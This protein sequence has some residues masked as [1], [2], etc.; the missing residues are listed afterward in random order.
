MMKDFREIDEKLKDNA[1]GVDWLMIL[2]YGIDMAMVAFIAIDNTYA[3]F[4]LIA[5]VAYL[6]VLSILLCVRLR[7]GNRF[8]AKAY[9]FAICITLFFIL[10][11]TMLVTYIKPVV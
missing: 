4:F 7:E 10:C 1:Q 3:K 8:I 2:L 9:I 11:A 6:T 5:N